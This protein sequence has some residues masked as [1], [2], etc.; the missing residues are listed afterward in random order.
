MDDLL[1]EK[2]LRAAE[3]VPPGE[4]ASYGDV[5]RVVGTGPRQVGAVMARHGSGVPWWRVVN[6]SGELPPD[7]L[8]E[9]LPHWRAEGITS[10][11]SG[12]GCRI[13]AHRT[14]LAVLAGRWRHAVADLDDH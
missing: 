13:D 9:A 5:A 2:V 11:A 10:K 3:L 7:V 6:A 12:R 14:D 8:A 1:I 4:V